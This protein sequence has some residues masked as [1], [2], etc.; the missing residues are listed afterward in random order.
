M[1]STNARSIATIVSEQAVAEATTRLQAS[2]E[3]WETEQ[4]REQNEAG[5]DAGV[6]WAAKN[7]HY[8]ELRNLQQLRESLDDEV[9]DS[10]DEYFEE[11]DECCYQVS[12]LVGSAILQGH[13]AKVDRQE[14]W[15]FWKS[16]GI[17]NNPSGHWLKGFVLGALEL[18]E[19]VE[20]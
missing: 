1:K 8:V 2:R 19:A 16:L 15:D 12:E 6:R 10:F 7:A 14:A 4:E 20:D 13:E 5:F 18:F 3:E 11:C 9:G 17:E